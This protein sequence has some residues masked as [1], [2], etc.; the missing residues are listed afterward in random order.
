MGQRAWVLGSQLGPT[1]QKK[2]W[3]RQTNNDVGRGRGVRYTENNDTPH[4]NR[5]SD[6]EKG[7]CER[8]LHMLFPMQKQHGVELCQK[9]L[10]YKYLSI[11]FRRLIPDLCPILSRVSEV[12]Y[13]FGVKPR[14]LLTEYLNNSY[15]LTKK[16]NQ[17]TCNVSAIYRENYTTCHPTACRLSVFCDFLKSAKFRQ[18]YVWLK[19]FNCARF[20]GPPSYDGFQG[21]SS[22]RDERTVFCKL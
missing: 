12:F 7:W 22:A 13:W 18:F 20:L 5:I 3:Q 15:G 11:D 1:S 19:V 9:H 17:F 16:K 14:I 8:V 10:T 2:N 4:F 21:S 6:E